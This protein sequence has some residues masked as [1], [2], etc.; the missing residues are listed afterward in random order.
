M[1]PLTV[2]LPLCDTHSNI[3]GQ[4][5][6]P[7]KNLDQYLEAYFQNVVQCMCNFLSNLGY[8]EPIFQ[9][10]W[11]TVEYFLHIVTLTL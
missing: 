3:G 9:Q 7:V 10:F 6:H 8:I 5:G 2:G 4:R 11:A 1:E